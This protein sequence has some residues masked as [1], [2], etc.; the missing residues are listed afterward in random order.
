VRFTN[1][2]PETLAAALLELAI[3]SL[4]A[5]CF[6]FFAIFAAGKVAQSTQGGPADE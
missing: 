3:V 4:C 2:E 5:W 1:Y 6:L